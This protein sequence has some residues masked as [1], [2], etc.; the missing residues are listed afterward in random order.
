MII[1][2]KIIVLHCLTDNAF[3][4]ALEKLKMAASEGKLDEQIVHKEALWFM[5][6]GKG[7]KGGGI[8]V[9]EEIEKIILMVYDSIRP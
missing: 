2:D 5:K 8:K 4:V 3:F 7:S 9:D 1:Q 6:I